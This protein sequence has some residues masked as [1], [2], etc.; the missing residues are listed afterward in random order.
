[1][2][3]KTLTYPL[4]DTDSGAVLQSAFCIL[5]G[6]AGAPMGAYMMGGLDTDTP[7]AG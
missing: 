2:A 7:A 5:F 4:D 6:T 1:M 3:W